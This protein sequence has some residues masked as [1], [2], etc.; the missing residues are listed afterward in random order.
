MT[1]HGDSAPQP[2]RG[3]VDKRDAISRGARLVFAR[4]GYTRASIDVIAVE[5]GVSTRTIYNHFGDKERLFTSVIL[6]SSAQVRDALIAQ[7][8][9]HLGT[10]TDLE[11]DL[12]ALAHAW[13]TTMEQ[14][15][16]HVAL[17]R[18]IT[19]EAGHLPPDLRQAWQN[20]GPRAAHAELARHIELLIQQ[21]LLSGEDPDRAATHFH[22]LTF[23]E[24]TERSRQGT[25]PL[26]G[27]E[28]N[29]IIRA[30]VRTF[31]HGYLSDPTGAR[32]SSTE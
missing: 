26:E 20:T 5:A 21:G 28:T 7:T 11:A 4:D 9:C 16:E 24:I 31:L 30:G 32:K 13:V 17:A 18:Q 15:A 23:S 10:V 14:F 25:E 19:A 3:W 8:R 12:I 2:R 6:E 29:E 22:L 27:T 1:D